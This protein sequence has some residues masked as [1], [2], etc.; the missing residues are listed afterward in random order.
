MYSRKIVL[1]WKIFHYICFLIYFNC[2]ILFLSG[3]LSRASITW[4]STGCLHTLTSTLKCVICFRLVL[5]RVVVLSASPARPCTPDMTRT[6]WLPS[7][8]PTVPL[9]CSS[10]K[11]Q[12]TFSSQE[13]RKTH[14]G[15][16]WKSNVTF[17]TFQRKNIIRVRFNAQKDVF[18]SIPLKWIHK[19]ECNDDVLLSFCV[20]FVNIKSSFAVVTA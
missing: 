5:E 2:I 13:R 10:P 11:N 19:T 4:S 9:R 14:E 20:L 8:G 15:G 3:T 6:D 12:C 16:L 18:P 17:F 1:D 7:P